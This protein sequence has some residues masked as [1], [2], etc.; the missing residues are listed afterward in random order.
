M[1]VIG[2]RVFRD[3]I[4][5]LPSLLPP[6]VIPCKSVHDEDRLDGFG[7]EKVFSR[8]DVDKPRWDSFVPDS[9]IDEVVVRKGN[10]N[11]GGSSAP[12]RQ[13]GVA[14]RSSWERNPLVSTSC[15]VL[16]NRILAAAS[17]EASWWHW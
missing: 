1:G 17:R 5:H 10:G 8:L 16:V 4:E 2:A 11:F 14:R 9:A 12:P 3:S 6:V 15:L 7:P 13:T